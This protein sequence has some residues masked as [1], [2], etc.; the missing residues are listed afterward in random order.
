MFGSNGFHGLRVR[1]V[2]FCGIGKTKVD[3]KRLTLEEGVQ[4]DEPE[5]HFRGG[6]EE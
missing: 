1:F 2:P 6:K 3:A 4:E 5:V